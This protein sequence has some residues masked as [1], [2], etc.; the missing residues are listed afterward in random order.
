MLRFVLRRFP[1]ETLL[2]AL[3]IVIEFADA[4]RPSANRECSRCDR[5]INFLSLFFRSHSFRVVDSNHLGRMHWQ[6]SKESIHQI[7]IH[8]EQM[9]RYCFS[10]LARRALRLAAAKC[11]AGGRRPNSHANVLK[12]AVSMPRVCFVTVERGQ[13]LLRRVAGAPERRPH[14]QFPPHAFIS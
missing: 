13:A 11:R 4:K 12:I 6:Q 3:N 1:S 9:N 10:S 2:F 14:F 8:I 5:R 7:R